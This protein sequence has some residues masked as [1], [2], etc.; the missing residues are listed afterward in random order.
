M[1]PGS[2]GSCARAGPYKSYTYVGK[3]QTILKDLL[4]IQAQIR[5]TESKGMMTKEGRVYL[6]CKFNDP[7]GMATYTCKSYTFSPLLN[8][9]AW[10]KQIKV[11]LGVCFALK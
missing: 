4:Y 7:Q 10:I 11:A 2:G 6:N 1:T 9:G 5:Q 8:S 3:M